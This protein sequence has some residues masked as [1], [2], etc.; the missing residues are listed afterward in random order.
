MT[1]TNEI[2]T[3]VKYLKFKYKYT[4]IMLKR[5]HNYSK[6]QKFKIQNKIL[7]QKCKKASLVYIFY[8]IAKQ[9]NQKNFFIIF[10]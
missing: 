1:L 2:F 8:L 9:Q 4:H 6:K 5:K 10:F 7:Y 3:Y